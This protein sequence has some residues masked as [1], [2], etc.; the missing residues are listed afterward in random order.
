MLLSFCNYLEMRKM[1]LIQSSGLMNIVA[2]A[3]IECCVSEGDGIGR[4]LDI[5]FRQDK[6]VYFHSLTC[7]LPKLLHMSKLTPISQ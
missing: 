6:E 4:N 5:S 3:A 2:T 7:Y 1:P